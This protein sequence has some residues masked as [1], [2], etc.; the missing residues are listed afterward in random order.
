[1]KPAIDRLM[2]KVMPEA[3]SGCWLWDG[4]IAANG[5]GHFWLAGRTIGAHVASWRLHHGDSTQGLFVLHRCDV[6]CCVNPAHLFLGTSAENM[7]D[8][9]RKGR[10]A[11]L[12]RKGKAHPLAKLTDESAA[13]IRKASASGVPQR[14]IARRVGVSQSTVSAVVTGGRWA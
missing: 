10:A 14:S 9:A 6:P 11:G 4:K 8:M 5:Y 3:L 13:E 2:D 7:A 12:R 1:M